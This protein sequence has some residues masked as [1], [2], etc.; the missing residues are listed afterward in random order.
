MWQKQRLLIQKDRQCVF[1]VKLLFGLLE[2]RLE[3]D[4]QV[5]QTGLD[6][7]LVKYQRQ[8]RDIGFPSKIMALGLKGLEAYD[9]L[10]LVVSLH[11]HYLIV[12]DLILIKIEEKL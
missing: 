1:V 5:W 4:I 6:L 9:V 11:S 12:T 2:D 10:F 7:L 3:H 8:R